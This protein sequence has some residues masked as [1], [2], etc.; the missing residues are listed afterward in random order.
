VVLYSK[1][2]GSFCVLVALLLQQF[3]HFRSLF[4]FLIAAADLLVVAVVCVVGRF[5]SH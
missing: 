1:L 5:H 2:I 4:N 3:S